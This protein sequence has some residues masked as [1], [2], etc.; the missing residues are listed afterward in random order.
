MP[1]VAHRVGSS[2]PASGRCARRWSGGA[3]PHSSYQ[4]V[5]LRCQ[6][7]WQVVARESEATMTSGSDGQRDALPICCVLPDGAAVLIR[8]ARPD[9]A[10]RLER[11]FY[12]L[13]PASI[14]SYFFLPLPQLPQWAARLAEVARATGVEQGAL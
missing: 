9:D 14:E 7:T 11:L 4:S 13:S 10:A 5:F 1:L 2:A 12:R 8:A 6:P 3:Q